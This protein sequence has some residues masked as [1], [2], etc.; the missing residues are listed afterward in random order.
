MCVQI[1]CD[2]FETPVAFYNEREGYSIFNSGV[3]EQKTLFN[4]PCQQYSIIMS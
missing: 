3:V 2:R 4:Q 1:S